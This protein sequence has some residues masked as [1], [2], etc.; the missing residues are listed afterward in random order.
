MSV[1]AAAREVLKPL[2]GPAVAEICLRSSAMKLGKSAEA[3]TASDVDVIA[4]EIR[5]SMRPFASAPL[6]EAAITEI[7]LRA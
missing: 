4:D 1:Y 3:F 5:S 6:L 2:V 7:R